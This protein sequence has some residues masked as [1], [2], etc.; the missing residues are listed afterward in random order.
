[1]FPFKY[2]LSTS[3][4]PGTAADPGD[5]TE[6]ETNMDLHLT[7]EETEVPRHHTTREG[8]SLEAMSAPCAAFVSFR[9]PWAFPRYCPWLG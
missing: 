3:W 4:K 8:Q 5:T 2:L 6:D 9:R 7:D 1:M